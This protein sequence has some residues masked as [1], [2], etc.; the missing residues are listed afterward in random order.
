MATQK[1]KK[2]F[3][4]DIQARKFNYGKYNVARTKF[5]VN[6]WQISDKI[7]EKTLT[8]SD[9]FWR[10]GANFLTISDK[11]LTN[12]ITSCILKVSGL[13]DFLSQFVSKPQQPSE[14]AKNIARYFFW[15]A[16]RAAVQMAP[17][18]ASGKTT[19]LA[20]NWGEKKL[21][22][23]KKIRKTTEKFRKIVKK[24][25]APFLS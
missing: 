23:E 20:T 7:A 25:W 4:Q 9:N 22:A 1:K 11:F 14:I 5:F 8:I 6:S 17:D 2:A 3:N 21:Q 18:G 13:S 24:F 16:P 19:E 10:T 15:Q 12:P